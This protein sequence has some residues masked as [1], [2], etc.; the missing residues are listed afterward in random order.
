M[1][2]VAIPTHNDDDNNNHIKSPPPTKQGITSSQQRQRP[3]ESPDQFVLGNRFK[4]NQNT[5]QQDHRYTTTTT[6]FHQ[7]NNVDTD[8]D[9]LKHLSADFGQ[10]LNQTDISDCLLNVKG[11]LH[12]I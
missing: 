9:L 10:L 12:S 6:S 11:K 1:T 8:V 3:V 4:S 2:S 5:N 7:V